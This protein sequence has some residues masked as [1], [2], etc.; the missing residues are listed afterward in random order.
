M[1]KNISHQSLLVVDTPRNVV[2]D[3]FSRL[4]RKDVPSALAGKK[5]T[6]IVSNSESNNEIESLGSSLTDDK[7][8]LE[9]LL[10]LPCLACNKNRKKRH[11][12]GRKE[13]GE[14]KREKR[15]GREKITNAVCE[16]FFNPKAKNIWG[17]LPIKNIWGQIANKKYMGTDC[18]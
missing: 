13:K 3:T 1:L 12:K 5:V 8:I 4:S 11:T 15:K 17:H 9:Y 16:E 2:A 18:K 14:K 6:H 7:K 10:N